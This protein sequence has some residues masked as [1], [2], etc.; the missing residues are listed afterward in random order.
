MSKLF[1]TFGLSF[2]LFACGGD[3][4]DNG[5]A[6]DAAQNV[7]LND[8]FEGVRSAAKSQLSRS[9]APAVSIGI[10][11]DGEIVFAEAFGKIAKGENT[12]VNKE[13]L[14]Q[15]GSTTKMF[16][17]LA[18]LRQIENETLS[19]DESIVDA[20]P[21]IQLEEEDFADWQEINLHH[22]MSHQSGLVDL[23]T[24]DRDTDNLQEFA[25]DSFPA[26]YGQ[27]NP[28]GRFW[29]YSNS[30]WSYL[31][32][33][34]EYQLDDFFPNIIEDEV[35]Q[36]LE[37]S[38]STVRK[39]DVLND[40][41]YALGTGFVRDEGGISEGSAVSLDD[42]N[43]SIFGTP[44]GANTW[45][46]PSEM[47]KMAEF[48]LNG[49]SNILSENLREEMIFPQVDLQA[50]L[51]MSYGYG[52]FVNEGFV[53][54][55]EWYPIEVWE[56]GGNTLAYTSMFWI[57]PEDNIAVVI[58]SSGRTTDFSS[59]MLEAIKSVTTLPQ[60]QPLPAEPIAYDLFP[61][62][63]GEYFGN[64]GKLE[65]E[66]DDG[67][68]KINLPSLNEEGISYNRT[69]IPKSGSVFTARIDGSDFDV[70]FLP[71]IEGDE[72][73]YIRHREFV[74]IREEFLLDLDSASD[75]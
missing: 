62:H 34:L 47:L 46:T 33:I 12:D 57:L 48:L 21:T 65:V 54:D 5:S 2:L 3:D 58:L 23:V 35:F 41:N 26:L 11:K 4:N 71:E 17:V 30:N 10:Y 38:R 28:A 15:M 53:I 50:G 56:H 63:V 42:V 72:S 9:I 49:N 52:I 43:E 22:L 74:A 18:T 61:N 7:E 66:L 37:M 13:T 19:I 73:I 64:F 25:Q 14:F 24:W 20:F 1:L 69:L 29:N 55:E 60:P 45:S 68:L 70:T 8:D 67:E 6:S 40:G 31:G 32:A 44:A 16:T 27:M 59:V 36:P 39:A 75:R 51:P